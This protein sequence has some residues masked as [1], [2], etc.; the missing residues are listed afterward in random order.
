MTDSVSILHMPDAD[1]RLLLKLQHRLLTAAQP[2]AEHTAQAEEN[3]RAELAVVLAPMAF[4]FLY[5]LVL[6]VIIFR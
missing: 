3:R 5:L 6:S 1:R 4:A 2:Q